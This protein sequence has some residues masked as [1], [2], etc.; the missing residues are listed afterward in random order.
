MSREE[1]EATGWELDPFGGNIKPL[2]GEMDHY[3]NCDAEIVTSED[4]VLYYK[5]LV[6]T[7]KEIM[8]NLAWRHNTIKNAIDWK[9]FE[10]GN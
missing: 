6:D 2:K 10:A 1:V 8:N 7:I 3:Y 5:N 9:K 4:K